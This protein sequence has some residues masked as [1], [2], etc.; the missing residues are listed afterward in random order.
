MKRRVVITGMGTV[1]PIGNDVQ[2]MWASIQKGVCGI[3]E[4]KSFDTSEYK[5]KL[6]Q[7]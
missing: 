7:A 4:I 6:D 3:D 1:N 5:V 2:S